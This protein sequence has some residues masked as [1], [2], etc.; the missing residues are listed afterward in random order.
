MIM[1]ETLHYYRNGFTTVQMHPIKIFIIP[2]RPC[3]DIFPLLAVNIDKHVDK[4][5][6]KIYKQKML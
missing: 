4:D 3:S 5:I 6:Q 1:K 2:Q